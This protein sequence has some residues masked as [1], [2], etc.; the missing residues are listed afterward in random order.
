MAAWTP[1]YN[2]QVDD[3]DEEGA[4]LALAE[5]CAAFR[6]GVAAEDGDDVEFLGTRQAKL[7]PAR[8]HVVPKAEPVRTVA[9]RRPPPRDTV[10]ALGATAPKAEPR[11]ARRSPP[12]PPRDTIRAFGSNPKPSGAK[13][14]CVAC[15]SITKFASYPACSISAPPELVVEGESFFERQHLMDVLDT[16]Y[17]GILTY[18]VR[19]ALDAAP[20]V[21]VSRMG[22]AKSLPAP[23]LPRPRATAR[24][25]GP[26]PPPRA[27]AIGAR[28][29]RLRPG[30]PTARG[31]AAQR[32]RD[33]G[34]VAHGRGARTP[35]R[36]RA[37]AARRRRRYGHG[38]AGEAAAATAPVVL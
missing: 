29:R 8:R 6:A 5:G 34:A 10:R 26:A 23:A 15:A 4:V 21:V 36:P 14:T 20:A 22:R 9:D 18:A 33:L 24:S 30:Q 13:C 32:L 1:E 12:L 31:D 11:P 2:T 25:H 7:R 35:R 28:G 17:G 27:S 37:D 3:A 16:R 19:A 38:I